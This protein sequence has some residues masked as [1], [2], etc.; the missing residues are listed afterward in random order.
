[1]PISRTV[2]GLLIEVSCDTQADWD[3][4]SF[5]EMWKDDAD[6]KMEG[7]ASIKCEGL[8]LS[9]HLRLSMN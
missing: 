7:A 5:S 4:Y 3:H 2:S 6:D 8:V 9:V 1:M